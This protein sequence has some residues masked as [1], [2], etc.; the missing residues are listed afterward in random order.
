MGGWEFGAA[1]FRPVRR[2]RRSILTIEA[3][4][5]RART[6]GEVSLYFGAGGAGVQGVSWRNPPDKRERFA[7]RG[8]CGDGA[9]RGDVRAWTRRY[10]G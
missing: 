7:R 10:G 3:F 9:L 6:A 2:E 1:G 5:M 8:A 4:G